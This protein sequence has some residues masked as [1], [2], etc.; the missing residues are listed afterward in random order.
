MK[1]IFFIIFSLC[2]LF[3]SSCAKNSIEENNDDVIQEITMPKPFSE[4]EGA[5]GD[6]AHNFYSDYAFRFGNIEST[7]SNLVDREKSNEWIDNCFA[8]AIANPEAPEKTLLDYIKYFDIPKEKLKEAVSSTNLPEGWIISPSD[9]DVIYS[10]DD[11]LINQT[12]VNEYALFYNGKIYSAEWLYEHSPTD[13]INEGLPL[14]EVTVCLEKMED[15]S[16]TEEAIA[17]LE[18][19]AKMLEKEYSEAEITVSPEEPE[20]IS[21]TEAPETD[22]PVSTTHAP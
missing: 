3:L 9:V 1:K 17:A 7:I 2:M 20:T 15:F 19:K 12:F 14:N 11:Y 16:L 21:I 4:K 6:S 10:G 18:A 8:E 5:G 13:Y 22:E